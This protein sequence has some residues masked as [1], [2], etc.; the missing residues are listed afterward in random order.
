M[1]T[2]IGYFESNRAAESAVEQLVAEKFARDDISI[3]ARD[4][5][6][7]S[8]V[9]EDVVRADDGGAGLASGATTGAVL[10]GAFGV[11][12]GL[13]A[14]I[15][16]G[17]GPVLAAGPLA[18]ALAGGAAGAAAGGVAGGLMGALIDAGVPSDRAQDYA[19]GVRRGGAI[20]TVSGITDTEALLAE[21]ILDDCDAQ[22]I[23]ER[24]SK[25][26]NAPL[27]ERARP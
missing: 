17:V 25:W 19:E 5:T 23:T 20:V 2:V 22:D 12:L 9:H 18:A 3:I 10:G 7:K 15:I 13:G 27:E 26:Q 4:T 6:T 1:R 16:P 8:D 24:A 11:A 21:R 14:L